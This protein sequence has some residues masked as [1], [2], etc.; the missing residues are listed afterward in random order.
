[1][2]WSV[3]SLFNKSTS[4]LS[5]FSHFNR[6][7]IL[8]YYLCCNLCPIPF[9]CACDCDREQVS[10]PVLLSLSPHQ[11]LTRSPSSMA[12]DGVAPAV[13]EKDKS[14]KSSSLLPSLRLQS[15][16]ELLVGAVLKAG[17]TGTSG[18]RPGGVG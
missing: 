11:T 10:V 18:T 5:L 13:P 6:A 1:M 7:R 14:S 2:R 16:D 17:P 8:P 15:L 4:L 12:G 3:G 9:Q